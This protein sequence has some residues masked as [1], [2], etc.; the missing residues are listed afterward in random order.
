MTDES[1]FFVKAQAICRKPVVTCSP[2]QDLAT[3]AGIMRKRNVS[4]VVVARGGIPVG[5]ITDR[6]IRN[7]LA[8]APG[9]IRYFPASA[10]MSSPLI[11]LN[12]DDYV[13]E[14]IYRMARQNVHR[15]VVVDPAGRLT[16]IL[17]NTDVLN[18]QTTTPL[19]FGREIEDA[20]TLADLRRLMGR[21]TELVSFGYRA[22][23]RTR[24]LIGLV[25]HF[26]D[27]MSRRV[28][29]ILL[30]EAPGI[31]PQ[32]Y[33]YLALGSE[34][35]RE[36]TLKTDQ[37]SAIV[38]PD[39]LSDAE[40]DALAAFS[41]RLIEALVQIGVPPCPGGTMANNP[42]WRR[43][44]R[45]WTELVE[46]WISEPIPENIVNFGMFCDLRTVEGDASLEAS[47][48]DRILSAIRRNAL[49]LPHMARNIL[50]FPPPLGFFGRVRVER[51]GEGRGR[52]DLKKAGI[53]AISEGVTLLGLEA[54]IMDGG[55]C[56]KLAELAAKG[57]L[58]SS[59]ARDLE[60]SFDFLLDLRLRNQLI[61]VSAGGKPTNFIDPNDLNLLETQRL[62]AALQ[63]V[64]SFQKRIRARYELDLIPS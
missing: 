1:F 53:F 33:A 16:G 58:S 38:Y 32:G 9:D 21:I 4:G 57:A 20:E 27:S 15:L 43:S 39:S 48:K 52:L 7:R 34:G 51:S 29:A 24:D 30:Q 10:V 6:D 22:G 26:Y 40:R 47:L 17:T 12:E 2:E 64:A 50:R 13:F 59:E 11:T 35:R 62:K 8:E 36:Q 23:A 56:G 61:E 25:S 54:G 63:V 60:E 5:M 19:Y 31:V 18:L 3:V 46:R 45:E 14:A 42:L 28:V 41:E 55:T 49:F 37:D 44:L